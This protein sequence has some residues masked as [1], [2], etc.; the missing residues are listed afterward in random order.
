M[1]HAL[2]AKVQIILYKLVCIQWKQIH[3]NTRHQEKSISTSFIC[4]EETES[5]FTAW[6]KVRQTALVVDHE[7]NGRSDFHWPIIINKFWLHRCWWQMM[8]TKC[9][10]DN[11]KITLKIIV[12]HQNLKYRNFVT[13]I[14]TNINLYSKFIFSNMSWYFLHT[15]CDLLDAINNWNY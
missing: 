12:G 8:E 15:V 10:G 11:F 14:V 7:V 13:K 6:S 9:V 1:E 4:H 5:E 2:I 3:Y